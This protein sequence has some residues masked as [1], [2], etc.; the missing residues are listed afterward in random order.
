MPAASPTRALFLALPLLALTAC[1]PVTMNL[2]EPVASV[3]PVVIEGLGKTL[4][5]GDVTVTRTK[6]GMI[7]TI[8]GGV[9]PWGGEKI[10]QK[11][12]YETSDG[13][14]GDCAFATGSQS[15]GGFE[16]AANG[17][18]MCTITGPGGASWALNLEAVLDQG[19]R[20]VGTYSDGTTTF[21]VAIPPRQGMGFPILGYEFAVGGTGVAAVQASG[22]RYRYLWIVEGTPE[23]EAIEASVGALLF[24]ESAVTQA[25]QG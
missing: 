17:G 24:S 9:G 7:T 4:T 10:K 18:L 5:M 12:Q 20:L 14:Q 15:M 11:F 6:G 3:S 23:V 13:W 1:E 22:A 19:K 8:S 25:T 16:I 21:D 2:R